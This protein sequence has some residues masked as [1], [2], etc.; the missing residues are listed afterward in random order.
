ERE[1]AEFKAKNDI[2]DAQGR[3]ITDEEILRLNEQLSAARARTSE[4]NARAAAARS[5]DVETV[6]GGALPEQ[7]ASPVMTELLA[8]Y[9]SLKQQ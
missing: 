7:V 6:L 1:V 5:L 3:L 9:A 4:L 2:G 8:Q